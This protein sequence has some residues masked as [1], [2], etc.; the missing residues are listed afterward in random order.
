MGKKVF[1]NEFSALEVQELLK[2]N[3]DLDQLALRL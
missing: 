1:L 2:K 3:E